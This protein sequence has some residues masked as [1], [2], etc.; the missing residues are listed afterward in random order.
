MERKRVGVRKY[1]F[2]SIFITTNLTFVHFPFQEMEALKFFQRL[3]LI[4]VSYIYFL[5]L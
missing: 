1:G 4:Y 5:Y 3:N 2:F